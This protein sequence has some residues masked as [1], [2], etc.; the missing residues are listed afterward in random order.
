MPAGTF[1][2]LRIVRRHVA[3]GAISAET[4]YAPEA[5]QF[6]RQRLYHDYGVQQRE[7]TSYSV[8]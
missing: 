6:V 5:R 3:S 8:R 4:W 2:A 1:R 7:M